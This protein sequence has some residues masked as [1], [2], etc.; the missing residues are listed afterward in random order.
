MAKEETTM[1]KI[2]ATVENAMEAWCELAFKNMKT[3]GEV[4]DLLEEIAGSKYLTS[5]DSDDPIYHTILNLTNSERRAFL[6]GC[7]RIKAEE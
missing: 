2:A 4:N 6:K 5:E 3:D 1:T 7:E